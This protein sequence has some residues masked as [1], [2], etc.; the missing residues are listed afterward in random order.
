MEEFLETY[1]IILKLCKEKYQNEQTTIQKLIEKGDQR[2]E[3]NIYRGVNIN[4]HQIYYT[5]AINFKYK[6]EMFRLI[7]QNQTFKVDK[8]EYYNFIFLVNEDPKIRTL[9]ELNSEEDLLMEIM[10]REKDFKR[11]KFFKVNWSEICSECKLI[12][13]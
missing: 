13:L 11:Y 2:I 7:Y 5:V 10:V 4:W 9:R 3:I 8:G 1:L 6:K 12:L